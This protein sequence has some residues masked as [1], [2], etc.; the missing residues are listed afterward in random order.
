M[1]KKSQANP[2]YVLTVREAILQ[3][4]T[5]RLRSVS[6]TG[7]K[8]FRSRRAALGR[9]ELPAAII[10]PVGDSGSND[11]TLYQSWDMKIN[12]RYFTRGD[13]PDVASEALIAQ[14][15]AAIMAGSNLG[16]L[17]LSVEASEVSYTLE[18]SE[19]IA[20]ETVVEYTVQYRTGYENWSMRI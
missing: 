6:D 2:E 8:V 18:A 20:C 17:A 3:A 1:M 11:G 4:F 7:L 14:A 16:G 10:E 12:V 5:E 9:Q 19:G 13:A 15:H